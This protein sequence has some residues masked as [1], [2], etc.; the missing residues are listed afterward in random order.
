[1]ELVSRSTILLSSP[2]QQSI[3]IEHSF[4][5]YQSNISYGSQSCVLSHLSTLESPHSDVS[6]DVHHNGEASDTVLYS[7]RAQRR[8][9]HAD[10]MIT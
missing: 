6:D 3:T 10:S 9:I 1:M 4:E 2:I 5:K 8:T 7:T